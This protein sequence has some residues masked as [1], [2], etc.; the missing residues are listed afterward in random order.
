MAAVT[1]RLGGRSG[2]SGGVIRVVLTGSESTGK[3]TLAAQL[4]GRYGARCV[5][6]FV[7]GFAERKGAPIEYS[8]HGAIARGQI[9]LEDEHIARASTLLIQ[10]T[11][12]LSTVVYCRHYFGVCPAW[13]EEAARTRRPD[14]YLLCEIDLPWVADGV[15][16][17]GHLREEM[18]QQFRDATLASGTAVAIVTGLGEARLERATE[19]I[20]A[21][22]LARPE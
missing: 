18:Q 10:D 20:D 21:L 16:D 12:L 1:R 5:P 2:A 11:D 22:L 9:A 7:R 15:R 13:I 6:E 17:R 4:A 14:L 19:A 3:S 8:D